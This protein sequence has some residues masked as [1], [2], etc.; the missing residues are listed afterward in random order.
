MTISGIPSP[1]YRLSR[2]LTITL[3]NQAFHDVSLFAE[4][5]GKPR[6]MR[7]KTS[8]WHAWNIASQERKICNPLRLSYIDVLTTLPNRHENIDYVNTNVLY[9]G[10]QVQQIHLTQVI[11][12][13]WVIYRNFEPIYCFFPAESRDCTNSDFMS[14]E[15][16][17]L[18]EGCNLF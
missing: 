15:R 10:S 6:A 17:R 1:L 14:I 11:L 5:I 4:P 2:W 7:N 9:S 16:L 3:P 8:I 12:K 13:V 18:K